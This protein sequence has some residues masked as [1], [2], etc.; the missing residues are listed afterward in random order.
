MLFNNT[1]FCAAWNVVF[2]FLQQIS[3]FLVMLLSVSRCIAIALPYRNVNKNRFLLA[4]HLYVLLLLAHNIMIVSQSG[5]SAY[6]GADIAYCYFWYDTTH[7]ASAK[8]WYAIYIGLYAIQVGIPPVVSFI[9]FVICTVKLASSGPIDSSKQ[10]NKLLSQ[11]Q[12]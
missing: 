7:S 1:V 8:I 9:S 5:I 6:Y 3:M 11:L 2:M 12:C 10:Q 4:F